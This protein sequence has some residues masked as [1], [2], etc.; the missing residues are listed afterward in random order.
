QSL[1]Q[2]VP[3]NLDHLRSSC[4][5]SNCS[6]SQNFSWVSIHNPECPNGVGDE[7]LFGQPDRRRDG[8]GGD[9]ARR[10]QPACTSGFCP[11]QRASDPRHFAGELASPGRQAGKVAVWPESWF[12][13]PFELRKEVVGV[14]AKWHLDWTID[15]DR[16]PP[17]GHQCLLVPVHD[18]RRDR[19]GADLSEADPRERDRIAPSGQ[20]AS[21][22][23]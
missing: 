14:T 13:P 9:R 7:V 4:E 11:M 8:D 16:D 5:P 20:E 6:L 23:G 21:P 10:R 2:L 12:E 22:A 18:C 17:D 3:A 19:S 15:W 1:E